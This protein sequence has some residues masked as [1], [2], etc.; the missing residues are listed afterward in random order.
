M[1]RFVD[2]GGSSSYKVFSDLLRKQENELNNTT[3]N[4]SPEN[5]RAA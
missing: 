3:I 2:R 1:K 4:P 5:N